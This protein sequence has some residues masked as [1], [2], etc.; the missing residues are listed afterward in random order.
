[1]SDNHLLSH[2]IERLQLEAT[3]TVT[4]VIARFGD[5]PPPPETTF[6]AASHL[7]PTIF[8][9]P[10]TLDESLSILL[11]L[12]VPSPAQL[13]DIRAL[14]EQPPSQSPT[15]KPTA[16][17]VSHSGHKTYVPIWIVQVWPRIHTFIRLSRVWAKAISTL[18]SYSGPP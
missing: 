12:P 11:S 7:S 8:T 17:S 16:L 13:S 2:V 5:I 3:R 10:D 6:V 18:I 9:S 14:L 1:M 15:I 4:D